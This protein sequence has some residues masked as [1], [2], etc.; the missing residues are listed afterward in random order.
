MS[1]VYNF[2][3]AAPVGPETTVKWIAIADLVRNPQPSISDNRF[4]TH[5]TSKA[6]NVERSCVSNGGSI[7]TQQSGCRCP[8]VLKM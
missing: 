5:H 1:E 3:T 6:W 7:R 8:G 4:L 2:V